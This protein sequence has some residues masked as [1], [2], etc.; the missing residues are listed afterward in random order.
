LPAELV[1]AFD[2][3]F[4]HTCFCAISP[5]QRADYVH[6][7]A[8]ALRRSGHVLGI[9]F[10]DPWDPGEEAPPEGGPPFGISTEELDELFL[11]DFRLLEQER[12]KTSYAGREGREILWLLR[13]R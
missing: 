3:V 5:G 1:G 4:E 9:F 11:P 10:L 13:K 7:V 2:W 6:A 12:P 8:T